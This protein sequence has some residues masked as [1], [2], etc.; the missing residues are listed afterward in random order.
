MGRI[1][2]VGLS[3]H[4]SR[5]MSV[6]AFERPWGP[7]MLP[8]TVLAWNR[9]KGNSYPQQNQDFFIP[10][11]CGFNSA[12]SFRWIHG[13][14]FEDIWSTLLSIQQLERGIL[15]QSAWLS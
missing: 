4:D 13:N 2:V 3:P 8:N 10:A 1:G 9:A 11:D 12:P 14:M 5:D 15:H 6:E 7:K